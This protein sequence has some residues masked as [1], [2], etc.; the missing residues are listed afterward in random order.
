[1]GKDTCVATFPIGVRSFNPKIGLFVPVVIAYALAKQLGGKMVLAVNALDSLI[2]ERDRFVDPFVSAVRSMDVNPDYIWVDSEHEEELLLCVRQLVRFGIIRE[3]LRLIKS[4]N[5]GRVIM[6][7]NA[8]V[9]KDARLYRMVPEGLR[10]VYCNSLCEVSQVQSLV[11]KFGDIG[12]EPL[13]F[14]KQASG[15]IR[16]KW[17]RISS[18]EYL[19]SRG[20]DTG[21]QL[22]LDNEYFLDIDSVWLQYLKC[23]EAEKFV[24]VGSNHVAWH[25]ALA[26]AYLRAEKPRAEIQIVLTPY[27]VGEMAEE[28]NSLSGVDLALYLLLNVYW[29]NHE[30]QWSAHNL[31]WLRRL[32]EDAKK[33]LWETITVESG[34]GVDI[35]EAVG[36]ISPQFLIRGVVKRRGG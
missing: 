10:C 6:L 24:L 5:C 11:L 3:E 19:I 8:P 23:I 13:A 17:Q 30:T 15:R 29:G 26:S 36:K 33:M 14:P 32:S 7:D 4:C 9:H 16:E 21:I 22:R 31:K 25:L 35:G 34:L 1:M 2:A 28:V 18:M 12:S 27:I 20:R